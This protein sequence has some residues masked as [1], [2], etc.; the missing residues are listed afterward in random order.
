MNQLKK[1]W[2]IEEREVFENL[3]SDTSN[4]VLAMRFACSYN[5][6]TNLGYKL[7]LKKSKAFLRAMGTT[8]NETGKP[9]LF[10][11]GSTPANKGKKV[12]PAVYDIMAKSFFSKGHAPH[13]TKYDG[14][15]RICKE[16]YVLI[17][18]HKGKYVLKHRLVWM[19][20]NGAIPKG[21][22]LVFKDGNKNNCSVENLELISKKENMVR[23]SINRFPSEIKE[24]I[25]L[26]NKL[27]RKIN[28][29]DHGTE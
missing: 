26:L 15:E 28:K 17:R 10:V 2:T 1:V 11:K 25:H 29:L 12:S 27:K 24:S 20:V 13:N 3:F 6:V 5:A 4:K 16:G 22:L 18:I 8:L 7:G 19:Q 9:Y 23:N 21:M 14:H